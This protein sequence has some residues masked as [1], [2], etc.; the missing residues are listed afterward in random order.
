M[1]KDNV[2]ACCE[3]CGEELRRDWR[4]GWFCPV[5]TPA[6]RDQLRRHRAG[7]HIFCHP[8]VCPGANRG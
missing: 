1:G 4:G 6:H 5:N 7:D 2:T 3:T 8:E